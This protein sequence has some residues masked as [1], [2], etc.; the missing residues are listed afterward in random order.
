[1]DPCA[2]CGQNP[3]LQNSRLFSVTLAS[4]GDPSN[5]SWV[6][7]SSGN[8]LPVDLLQQLISPPQMRDDNAP[9][10]YQRH[11]KRLFLFR[12]RHAQ[13][14]SLNRV[15]EDAIVAAQ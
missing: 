10:H 12:A 13:A 7:L 3:H 15:I 4:S 9:T 8:G 6:E 1:M 14:I 11:I 2:C 5:P